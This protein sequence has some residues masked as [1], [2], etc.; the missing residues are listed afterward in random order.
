MSIDTLPLM[1]DPGFSCLQDK[2][3]IRINVGSISRSV[4]TD[5]TEA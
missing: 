1:S 5:M 3:M 2:D 4:T